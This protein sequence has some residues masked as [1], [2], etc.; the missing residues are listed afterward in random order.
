MD[1]RSSAIGELRRRACS[2][3]GG[4][5]SV[6]ETKS[7]S[8]RSDSGAFEAA[9]QPGG[10]NFRGTIRAPPD[11]KGRVKVLLK[12]LNRQVSVRF[13]VEFIKDGRTAWTP[14]MANSTPN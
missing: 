4:R 8:A 1:T 7:R 11:D 3:S 14:A 13:G 5:R 9:A 12:L 10:G 2:N 6:F